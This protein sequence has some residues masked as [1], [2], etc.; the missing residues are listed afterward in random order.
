M[1]IAHRGN[2]SHQYRENSEDAILWSL[3]QS[4]IDGIECDLRLTK[5]NKIIVL[6]N[7]LIDFISDGSGFV[8]RKTLDELLTY[9]FVYCGRKDHV[10][11][12]SHLLSKIHSSKILLLEIKEERF[13]DEQW[14]KSLSPILKK[15]KSLSIYLCSF[16]YELLK[17]LKSIYTSVPMG[18][19]VGY[20]M[21]QTKDITP[22][23][24]VMYQ[25]DCF[26]YTHKLSMIWT[27]NNKSV[28]AKYKT[29]VDYIITDV[30]YKLV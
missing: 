21:N 20:T 28:L 27:V 7:M 6:H 15:Y 8:H 11:V 30:A 10:T 12:L 5:D 4:Y 2:D 23:D 3:N 22:F 24:F 19:I 14:I 17:K 9:S 18:L 1:F 25:Y 13:H 16:N 26:K 29:R